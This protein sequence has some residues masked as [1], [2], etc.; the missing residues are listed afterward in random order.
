MLLFSISVCSQNKI[1]WTVSAGG[2][3]PI[4]SF[5]KMEYDSDD[6]STDCSLFDKGNTG[7]AFAGFNL[8][9]KTNVALIDEKLGILFS[10]DFFYNGIN[11]QSKSY[12]TEMCNYLAYYWGQ[13]L[14]EGEELLS[15]TCNIDENPFFI[16][17]PILI[18]LNYNCV[19]PNEMC[20]FGEFGI[21]ANIRHISDW[22]LT[23]FQKYIFANRSEDTWMQVKETFSYDNAVTFAFRIGVG[24]CFT[25]HCSLSLKYNYLGKGNVNGN[26]EATWS[27][28][29]VSPN[30][31]N[32]PVKLGTI[33]PSLL[34]ITLEY[35]F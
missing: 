19:L 24:L 12:M 30:T 20:L 15:S 4:G 31:S 2:A 1:R 11:S 6:L 17:V 18:G 28:E 13:N 7:G 26:V 29:Y 33:T 16:N 8:G 14:G 22:K 32:Q 27:A 5:S 25:K 23:G 10:A 9:L 34:S 21:G 3:L 35:T